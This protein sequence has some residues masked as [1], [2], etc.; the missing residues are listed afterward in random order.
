MNELSGIGIGWVEALLIVP[1]IALLLWALIDVIRRPQERMRYLP[2]WGW[3]LVVLFGNTL[4]QIAYLALG[5]DNSAPVADQH[6]SS[7]ET[8]RSAADALYGSP[9]PPVEQ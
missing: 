8:Q 6:V 2:K 4:G 9:Q 7:A 5:R 3:I 1:F